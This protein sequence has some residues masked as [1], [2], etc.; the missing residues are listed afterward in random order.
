M[1]I[2]ESATIF[3][4]NPQKVFGVLDR[5]LSKSKNIKF[6]P[7]TLVTEFETEDR[8]IKAIVNQH[9]ERIEA[10]EFVVAA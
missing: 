3:T 4:V 8:K 2:D 1:W 7:D 9:G 5:Q 6:M 10:D